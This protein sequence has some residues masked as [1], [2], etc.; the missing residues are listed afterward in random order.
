[1]TAANFARVFRGT[2]FLPPLLAT[3]VVGHGLSYLGRRYRLR[4][5]LS[6]TVVG[7]GV[8]LV[9][10]W[11][12]F[13][14]STSW[15]LPTIRTWD[16]VG[17]AL[18][19]SAVN[20]HQLQA[21][22]HAGPGFLFIAMIAVG[23]SAIWADWAAFRHQADIGALTAPF[24]IFV[25]T[26]D[27]GAGRGQ[28]LSTAAWMAAVLAYLVLA[29]HP[30]PGSE[31]IARSA[32]L[33]RLGGRQTPARTAAASLGIV[34][35]L[36]GV[37]VGPSLPGAGAVGLI[38]TRGGDNSGLSSR[39]TI[40]P[41]VDIR[42]RLIE[43]GNTELFTVASP[44]PAYWRL[45]SLDHFD[46]NVWSS[47]GSY[48]L[49]PNALPARLPVAMSFSTLDQHFAISK[50]NSVWLPAAWQ[51]VSIRDRASVA[52]SAGTGSVLTSG[53]S[54][55]HSDYEVFSQIPRYSPTQLAQARINEY[56]PVAVANLGLPPGIPARVI[57]LTDTVIRGHNTAYSRALALQ[58]YF[59][60][61]FTYDLNVPAGHSDSAMVDFLDSK[62]G[63]CEQFAGTFAVMARLAGLPTRVA[64]GFTPGRLGPDGRY[65]VTGADA[66]AWPEVWMGQFGWV[67][68]E[69][70]PGRGQPGDQSYTGVRPAQS[71]QGA[72]AGA[73][74]AA[75]TVPAASSSP[76]SPA[77]GRSHGVKGVDPSGQTHG[78]SSGLDVGHDLV[79]GLLVIALSVLGWLL[80]GLV[81][82]FVEIGRRRRS[83]PLGQITGA[84]ADAERSLALSGHPRHSAET[85]AA[86]ARRLA[87]LEVSA[88]VSLAA[89][90]QEACYGP[91]MM[92]HQAVRSAREASAVIR[93]QARRHTPKRQLLR[94]EMLR[95]RDTWARLD[96]WSRLKRSRARRRASIQVSD[97]RW[98]RID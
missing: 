44:A 11:V 60:Q 90:A 8:M 3:M 61:N 14:Q 74:G 21:P 27:L 49:D 88:M 25:F 87:A 15:G 6:L 7:I 72:I 31:G 4:A 12:N 26:C 92:N 79:V 85:M 43:E 22:V 71:P 29:R 65:H 97:T 48:V 46:G 70:T 64:V 78:R 91:E 56:G 80:L 20:F 37:I 63:Y 59:R 39:T 55:D 86:Y 76:A 67:S 93:G 94:R 54:S 1:M 5:G 96:Y 47:S 89:A 98:A 95:P 58:S 81:L 23:A 10:I 38:H 73:P 45:T 18:S 28:A 57:N 82:T 84:W 9:G 68:F 24:A 19:R 66:H 35:L 83:D 17:S 53:S 77:G 52:Y 62:R 16:A 36:A 51:P 75:T 30:R 2:G 13:A 42:G 50:L 33:G 69:P 32:A 40:S 41:L 34:A